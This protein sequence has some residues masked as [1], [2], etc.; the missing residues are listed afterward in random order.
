MT[1]QPTI[2]LSAASPLDT[3]INASLSKHGALTC[4]SKEPETAWFLSARDAV[5]KIENTGSGDSFY[6]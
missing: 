3:L 6:R 5:R 4:S 2:G 1:D